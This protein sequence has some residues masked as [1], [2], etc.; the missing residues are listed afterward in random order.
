[1]EAQTISSKQIEE[2]RQKLFE[3]ASGI[4]NITHNVT[5]WVEFLVVLLDDLEFIA[6]ANDNDHPEQ[7]EL[8]LKRL[9]DEIDARLK[10]R[11]WR[12]RHLAI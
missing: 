3:A 6:M 4:D 5:D 2:V 11:S 8:M 1:M 9:K 12:T 10:D 7:Y